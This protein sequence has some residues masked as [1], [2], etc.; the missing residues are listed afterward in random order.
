VDKKGKIKNMNKS[1]NQILM[2]YDL[3]HGKKIKPEVD[4][5]WVKELSPEEYEQ[6]KWE[7][8]NLHVIG[9]NKNNFRYFDYYDPYEKIATKACDVCGS[10]VEIDQFGYGDCKKCGWCQDEMAKEQPDKVIYPNIIPLNKAKRLYKLGKKLKPDIY[11]FV[12]GLFF[13]SEMR[14]THNFIDYEV[15]LRYDDM[16]VFCSEYMQQEYA[17]KEDFIN[18]ANIDGRLLKDIWDEVVNADYMQ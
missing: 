9:L 18:K 1:N 3:T 8:E 2:W 7:K 5:E 13:Y 10:I 15:F 4:P 11:D 17:T 16:I 14:F 6:Y 12:G